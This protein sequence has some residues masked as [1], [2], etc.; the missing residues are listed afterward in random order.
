MLPPVG[1]VMMLNCLGEA[2]RIGGDDD[3]ILEFSINQFGDKFHPRGDRYLRR[4]DLEIGLARWEYEIEGIRVIKEIQMPWRNN[5]VGIRYTVDPGG[6][7]VEL[8]LLPFVRM[9]DFHALRH[10]KATFEESHGP[11]TCSLKF[12]SN[13]LVMNADAGSFQ[14]RSGLVVWL[15]VCHRSRT[16]HG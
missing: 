1:R 8:S 3:R 14:S 12:D 4:F 13:K 7:A 11:R 2:L 5:V 15:Y 6:R 16:G 9:M 10:E